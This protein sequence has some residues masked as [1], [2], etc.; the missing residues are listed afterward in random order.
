[1]LEASPPVLASHGAGVFCSTSDDGLHWATPRRVLE[2][3]ETDGVRV[4]DWPVKLLRLRSRR[5]TDECGETVGV[6]T[7]HDIYLHT[8]GVANACR[9]V[10]DRLAQPFLCDDRIRPRVGASTG[11]CEQLERNF[12]ARAA[13]HVSRAGGGGRPERRGCQQRARVRA[14]SRRRKRGERV[15]EPRPE[16]VRA[17]AA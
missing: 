5:R 14:E 11:V 16:P 7:Q 12:A 2:S 8:G 6:L 1:M 3:R 10:H 15:S 9:G 13:A 4:S 17:R